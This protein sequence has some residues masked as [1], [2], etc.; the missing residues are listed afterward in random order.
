M[1]PEPLTLTLSP[2]RGNQMHK[3][4]KPGFPGLERNITHSVVRLQRAL[5][6]RRTHAVIFGEADYPNHLIFLKT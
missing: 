1:R 3:K 4:T 2:G 5:A 6:E